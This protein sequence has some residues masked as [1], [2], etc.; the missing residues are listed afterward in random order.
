MPGIFGEGLDTLGVALL[1]AL[2]LLF[3]SPER[4]FD[5]PL[6]D[7]LPPPRPRPLPPPLG[8]LRE[9]LFEDISNLECRSAAF[10]VY[11]Y[12][13]SIVCPDVLYHYSISKQ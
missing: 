12:I 11:S 8:P 2:E 10:K 1:L 3:L 9:E 5:R 6:P 13:L 4:L 7:L